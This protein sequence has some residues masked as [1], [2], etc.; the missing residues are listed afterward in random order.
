VDLD[1]KTKKDGKKDGEINTNTDTNRITIDEFFAKVNNN[2]NKI[3]ELN[4]SSNNNNNNNHD[5]LIDFGQPL[6]GNFCDKE[7]FCN[8][9]KKVDIL[10]IPEETIEELSLEKL[11]T[12]QLSILNAKR[13]S[14]K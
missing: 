2:N 12:K 3:P 13:D 14:F 10:P 6:I 1:I 8:T 7:L 11:V 4:L 9:E 5:N